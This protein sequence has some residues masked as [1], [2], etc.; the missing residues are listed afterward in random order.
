MRE[1]V[2]DDYFKAPNKLSATQFMIPDMPA[3]EAPKAYGVEK[4]VKPAQW[5]AHYKGKVSPPK[6]GTYHFVGAA[7]DVLIVRFGG[8]L[9]L[10]GSW[11]QTSALKHGTIYHN[12]YGGHPDQGFPQGEAFRA[13]AGQWYDIDVVIGE[14]P[15]GHFWTCLCIEEQGV[16]YKKDGKGM[17][18]FPLFRFSSAKLPDA[19]KSKLPP[20]D[21]N[22]PIWKAQSSSGSGSLLDA[23]KRP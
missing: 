22:G 11:E 10:D 5:V 8:K 20:F 16:T 18:L 21:E 17:P 1:N 4:E 9:V 13:E 2:I 12:G 6:S 7:D 23:L 14:R 15:G 3:D 19:G